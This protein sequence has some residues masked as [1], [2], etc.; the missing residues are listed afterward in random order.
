MNVICIPPDF[1]TVYKIW[2]N[3]SIIEI[4][5]SIFTQEVV[6]LLMISIDLAILFY[7]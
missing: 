1:C 7:M 4:C 3:K 6:S 2:I 5:W